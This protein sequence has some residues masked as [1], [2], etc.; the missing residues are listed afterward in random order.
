MLTNPEVHMLAQSSPGTFTFTAGRHPAPSPPVS[1]SQV[2]AC[3]GTAEQK[4][5]WLAPLLN[6]EI[7][8]CFA[9]TEP[10]SACSDATNV[11]VVAS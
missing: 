4:A 5:R 11:Q 8:S 7:R 10:Q 3:F 9:M 2:L 1:Y 6:G